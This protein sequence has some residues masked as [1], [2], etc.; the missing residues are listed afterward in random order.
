METND[1]C[2]DIEDF[3]PLDLAEALARGGLEVSGV[4]G[5]PGETVENCCNTLA[6]KLCAEHND[7]WHVQYEFSKPILIRGYGV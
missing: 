2:P 7:D 3:I 1:E 6:R 4:Q 5:F